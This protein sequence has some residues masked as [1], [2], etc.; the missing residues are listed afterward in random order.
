MALRNIY[1]NSK[2]RTYR[3]LPNIKILFIF[4]FSYK[5]LQKENRKI[6]KWHLKSYLSLAQGLTKTFT[7]HQETFLPKK[8]KKNGTF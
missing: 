1:R 7:I 2:K 5:L 4:P 8:L 6:R 3:T